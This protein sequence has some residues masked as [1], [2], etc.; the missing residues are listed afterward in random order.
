M[1]LAENPSIHIDELDSERPA[2]FKFQV[3]RNPDPIASLLARFEIDGAFNAVKAWNGK[4]GIVEAQ[5]GPYPVGMG[6][7]LHLIDGCVQAYHQPEQ[8]EGHRHR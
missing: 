5:K 6:S 1:T 2:I 7:L 3:Q 8:S 4:A